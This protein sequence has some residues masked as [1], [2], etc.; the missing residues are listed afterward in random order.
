MAERLAIVLLATLASVAPALWFRLG[1]AAP[2]TGR[3]FGEV[4]VSAQLTPMRT[5]D[6]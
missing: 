1:R 2:S 6:P 3:N 5:A 4:A